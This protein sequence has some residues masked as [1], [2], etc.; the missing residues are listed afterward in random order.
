MSTLNSTLKNLSIAVVLNE[1]VFKNSKYKARIS[2]ANYRWDE[3]M[4]RAA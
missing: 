1:T 2:L 3:H 4:A